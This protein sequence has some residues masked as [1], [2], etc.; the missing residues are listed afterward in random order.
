M[1]LVEIPPETVPIVKVVLGTLGVWA[2]E[3]NPIAPATHVDA[4]DRLYAPA[5]RFDRDETVDIFVFPEQRF[6][7]A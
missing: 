6:H 7:T 2:L 5:G 3:G 1:E 4:A